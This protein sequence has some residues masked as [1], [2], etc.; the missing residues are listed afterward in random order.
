M[1]IL[2]RKLPHN[3]G[4]QIE[5]SFFFQLMIN[6]QISYRYYRNAKVRN[7][8][9]ICDKAKFEEFFSNI[10]FYVYHLL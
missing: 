9:D 7:T 8:I 1:V 5:I 6:A 2:K 3:R 4:V 10:T